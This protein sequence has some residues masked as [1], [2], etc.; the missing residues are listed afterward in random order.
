M[1]KNKKMASSK[2]MEQYLK[3]SEIL[4]RWDADL[5][6]ELEHDLRQL[7]TS[8]CLGR[9]LGSLERLRRHDPIMVGE[10]EALR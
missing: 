7:R 5:C 9:G 3:A 6:P 8:I 2:Q 1:R 10:L 4:F